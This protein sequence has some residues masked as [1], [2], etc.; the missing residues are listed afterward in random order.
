MKYLV[1]CIFSKGRVSTTYPAPVGVGGSRPYVVEGNDLGAVVSTIPNGEMSKD[2]STILTY[3]KVIESF[4]NQ[5][6]VIPLR[7]GTV[8][9]E[10]AEIKHYLETQSERYKILLTKLAGCVEIGIRAIFDDTSLAPEPANEAFAPSPPKCPGAGAAYMAVRKAYHDAKTLSNEHNQEMI[11]RYRSPF[12]NLFVGFKAE[13]TKAAPSGNE[14]ETVFLSLYFLVPRLSVKEF[15]EV[16]DRLK[17]RETS[18][19]LLSGPWPP[20]NFV[21]PEDY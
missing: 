9:R 6:G 3:H 2:A 11:G 15:R 12:E 10:Q 17:S 1:Y 20:Y 13:S 16:F 18:R 7:F 14:S 8:V 5:F 4:H 19:L 21:L